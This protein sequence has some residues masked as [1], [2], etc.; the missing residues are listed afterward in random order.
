M[1]DDLESTITAALIEQLNTS[2]E[3]QTQ[4]IF[5]Q[6]PDI[7]KS[8]VYNLKKSAAATMSRLFSSRRSPRSIAGLCGQECIKDLDKAQTAL[9]ISLA[10]LSGWSAERISLTIRAR[11][12]IEILPEE[13]WRYFWR[14][15]FS[16]DRN[17]QNEPSEAECELM[18]A[19]IKESGIEVEVGEEPAQPLNLTCEPVTVR[20]VKKW[21]PKSFPQIAICKGYTPIAREASKCY[22]MTMSFEAYGE[23]TPIENPI[24][25]KFG[26]TVKGIMEGT[27]RSWS[28]ALKD[29]LDKGHPAQAIVEREHVAL[30]MKYLAVYHQKWEKDFGTMEIPEQRHKDSG[31][32]NSSEIYIHSTG[33]GCK[34]LLGLMMADRIHV[35]ERLRRK[36]RERICL[37][38]VPVDTLDEN[39]QNCYICTEQMGVETPEGACE[40]PIRLAICCRNIMGEECLKI[41]LSDACVLGKKQNDSC[42]MCRKKFPDI[43]L[44]KLF[45]GA[46]PPLRVPA[47][48]TDDDDD[49]DDDEESMHSL[50]DEHNAEYPREEDDETSYQL[51]HV[52][53]TSVFRGPSPSP[54]SYRLSTI[55][56]GTNFMMVQSQSSQDARPSLESNNSPHFGR[57]TRTPTVRFSPE[58]IF[59]PGAHDNHRSPGIDL[60]QALRTGED[61]RA[62]R[63]SPHGA[64][65]Y[66]NHVEM[67][68]PG[69]QA[70]LETAAGF[71]REGDDFGW[72]G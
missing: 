20:F 59:S 58:V 55:E 66:S 72:E 61:A 11:T 5:D 57:R 70:L 13:I 17:N 50:E 15:V 14:W 37:E 7:T 44:E 67:R 3:A 41:W 60:S 8:R 43:F 63:R 68:S 21:S 42:P 10:C 19:A 1:A 46:V 65:R 29:L 39:C 27:L 64:R 25:A 33:Y 28:L 30:I 31:A 2:T 71:L 49:D 32:S 54:Q 56:D 22:L 26:S 45:K 12:S 24:V 52:T 38:V 6:L 40:Q 23:L 47:D 4:N 9:V 36:E 62:R 34:V 16:L 53:A 35:V 51:G 18:K 69:T 48:D